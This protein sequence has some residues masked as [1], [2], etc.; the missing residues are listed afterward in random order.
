MA[1]KSK[2]WAGITIWMTRLVFHFLLSVSLKELLRRFAKELKSLTA[3]DKMPTSTPCTGC[4][5]LFL[6]CLASEIDA[7]LTLLKSDPKA[8]ALLRDGK[9]EDFDKYLKEKTGL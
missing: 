3:L 1:P 6:Q 2:Q 4:G 8:A 9:I 7:T 5:F